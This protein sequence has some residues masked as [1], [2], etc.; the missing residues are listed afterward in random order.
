MIYSNFELDIDGTPAI[1]RLVVRSGSDIS[2][3]K[4]G[5][6]K[7]DMYITKSHIYVTNEDEKVDS[8]YFLIKLDDGFIPAF[9]ASVS[10]PGYY[11]PFV[12]CELSL[13]EEGSYLIVRMIKGPDLCVVVRH[14]DSFSVCVREGCLMFFKPTWEYADMIEE[15]VTKE[16]YDSEDLNVTDTEGLWVPVSCKF[17][18][19]SSFEPKPL[20]ERYLLAFK[21][22]GGLE[23]LPCPE[24]FRNIVFR[25]LLKY[26]FKKKNLVHY[27]T[28]YPIMEYAPVEI[29]EEMYDKYKDTLDNENLNFIQT[30][31]AERR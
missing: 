10:Y 28:E 23:H 24:A 29:V 11:K 3:L 4:K 12:S 19:V 22:P 5:I 25:K 6:N 20:M 14:D 26:I 17:N 9:T 2:F 7:A 30:L 27:F 21:K 1:K 31:L 16:L 13:S 15:G 18:F 8:D